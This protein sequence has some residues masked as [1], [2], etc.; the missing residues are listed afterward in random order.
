MASETDKIFLIQADGAFGE[1]ERT[2]Y[3]SEDLLQ[4]LLEQHPGLLAGD[5]LAPGNRAQ[6]LLVGR[7]VG[8]PDAEGS[9]DRW[10]LDHLFVDQNATPTFVEVKRSTDTRIRREVVGQMLDYAANAQKYWPIERIQ[11]FAERSAGG[12]EQL[13][14]AVMDI[15][16]TD[17]SDQNPE[18]RVDRFWAQAAE[19]LRTGKVRL[20]FVADAIPPELKRI[21]EFL[22]EQMPR[23][24]VVGLELVQY[25]ASGL[26]I[27]VPRVVGQTEAAIDGKRPSTGRVP[28]TNREAFLAKCEKCSP[29]AESFFA[30]LLD[31]ANSRGLEVYWGEQGFSVR[32]REELH[33][34]RGSFLYGWPPLPK[35]P[36]PVFEIYLHS[37][38]FRGE[39]SDDLRKAVVQAGG[40]TAAG[41]FTLRIPV[42]EATAPAARAGLKVMLDW[43]ETLRMG[44]NPA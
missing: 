5:M 44:S 14:Q 36:E 25:H 39:E 22:N 23:V 12:A 3:E 1:V 15:I 9:S 13:T 17:E 31:Q 33:R 37:N 40:F 6:F 19:N 41:D 10:A 42:T 11:S 35:Y 16:G 34:R 38:V 20:V 24:H 21:I 2:P 43:E 7:E 28:K 27:L 26:R 4:R 30:D 29:A 32:L 18:E 8:V